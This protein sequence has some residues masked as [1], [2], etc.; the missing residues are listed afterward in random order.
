[1][2]LGSYAL[3]FTLYVAPD[4]AYHLLAFRC[5]LPSPAKRK[6]VLKGVYELV[7]FQSRSEFWLGT[8]EE[9]FGQHDGTCSMTSS[10]RL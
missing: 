3:P 6:P 7:A 10:L 5:G 1:M 8:R 2:V 4:L 9:G